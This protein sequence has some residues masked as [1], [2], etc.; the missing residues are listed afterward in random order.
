MDQ[1]E[2]EIEQ[3]RTIILECGLEEE[4]KWGKPTFTYEGKNVVVVQ[5]FKNYLGLLFMKG[6]M[7][8]DPEGILQKL[9]ENTRIGRT[10]KVYS[11]KE[12][13]KMRS[14][15]KQYIYD[16]I[17]LEKSGAK[18]TPKKTLDVAIPEELEEQF[19][20]KPAFKSAF[21]SMTVGKQRGY[22]FHFNSAKQSA[23]RTARIEKYIPQIMKGIG[24]HDEYVAA[25]K[26]KKAK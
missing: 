25:G 13:V 1:W 16:A 14:V 7:M 10:I 12:I 22:I 20:K 18:V 17:E 11:V 4:E 3:L 23:T 21:F 9:G 6:F 5:G 24:I 2:K 19:R 15:L 8:A 26:K